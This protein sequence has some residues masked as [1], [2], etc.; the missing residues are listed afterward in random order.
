MTMQDP[1]MAA[2]RDLLTVTLGDLRPGV[3]GASREALNWRP[4]N[5]DTNS[6]AVLALHSMTSTRWW[7][8]VAVGA[9]L[10]VRDRDAEFRAAATDAAALLAFID[11][12]ERD[13]LA[14]L[15]GAR[16]VD[17]SA[18]R[19]TGPRPRPGADEEVTAA[20]ALVHALQHLR[21]HAGQITLTRQLWDQRARS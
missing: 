21:E 7:L 20:W 14:L 17:W 15:D 3:E 6:I 18:M 1:V 5:E 19:R 10:P 11:G 2:A 8:S 16:D 9:P 4:G 12:M 13:C